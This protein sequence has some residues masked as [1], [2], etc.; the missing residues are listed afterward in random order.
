VAQKP[1]IIVTG[2]SRGI[3]REAV[4]HLRKAGALVIATARQTKDI[5]DLAAPGEVECLPLDVADDASRAACIAEV[6]QRFGRIDALVNNAGYGAHL[7][8]EDTSAD[9]LRAMLEVNLVGAH[10]L[11]RRVLPGMRA[12]HGGRIVNVGSVA[13]QISVPMMGPYCASKF[14]LRALTQAMDNEVRQFGIRCLLIEPTWIATSFGQR[15]MQESLSVADRERSAYKGMYARWDQRRADRH[16]PH[17]RVVARAIVRACMAQSPRF[18]N[19]VPGLAKFSN[20]LRRLLPDSL[21]SWG[22]RRYFSR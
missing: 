7:T 4:L 2:A 13:G 8:V 14:A 12:A 22:M 21:L 19:F 11:A 17:P 3:G 18:H 20:V 5:A 15:T 16:G 1:V 9:K 6:L 10:D